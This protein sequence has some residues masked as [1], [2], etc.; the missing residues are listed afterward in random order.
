MVVKDASIVDCE[1]AGYVSLTYEQCQDIP[2]GTVLGD[3]TT[4]HV[5]DGKNTNTKPS[6]CTIDVYY[7]FGQKRRQVFNVKQ[8]VHCGKGLGC[9]CFT[10]TKPY[11]FEATSS[12][13]WVA[14]ADGEGG[15]QHVASPLETST[16]GP[17]NGA[18][19]SKRF[20]RVASPDAEPNA[21]FRLRF[22]G[23]FCTGVGLQVGTVSFAYHMYGA[24][25]GSLRLFDSS[26]YELW[27]QTGEQHGSQTAPWSRAE[28]VEVHDTSFVFVAA[29]AP[30]SLTVNP[31]TGGL[32]HDNSTSDARVALDDV[33]VECEHPSPTVP[34]AV[35][36]PSPPPPL[37]E[38]A[39]PPPPL[40]VPMTPLS[41]RG[42][43]FSLEAGLGGAW[44]AEGWSVH[45]GA[46]RAARGQVEKSGPSSALDGMAYA[47]ME[48]NGKAKGQ[49][50]TLSY[51][52]ADCL[53]GQVSTMRF[54]YHMYSSQKSGQ[55]QLRVVDGS[56][57]LLWSRSGSTTT[58][59]WYNSDDV[60]VDHASFRFEAVRGPRLASDVAVD[61]VIV[62]RGP[63]SSTASP[64]R[65]PP[66][67]PDLP[68]PSPLPF[69]SPSP[70]AGSCAASCPGNSSYTGA[71]LPWSDACRLAAC[72][73]CAECLPSP[74]PPPMPKPPPFP[75]RGPAPPQP[76]PQPL[77]PLF[78]DSGSLYPSHRI[79]WFRAATAV[80]DGQ[81]VTWRDVDNDAE[82][83]CTG[84]GFSITRLAGYGAAQPVVALA[85][86]TKSSIDFGSI[87]KGAFD[88]ALDDTGF[89]ICSVTRYTGSVRGRILSMPKQGERG[90]Y[91]GHELGMAGVADYG[92]GSKTPVQT[93]YPY[94]L[95]SPDYSRCPYRDE[96]SIVYP[97]T[98]KDSRVT[99]P[100]SGKGN[101][102]EDF[103]ARVNA[104]QLPIAP[105]D[106][107]IVCGTD[108]PASPFL[109]NGEDVSREADEVA[110]SASPWQG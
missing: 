19:G 67:P 48:A 31:L 100:P 70:P 90:F 1:Q 104:T 92:R 75:P 3:Y 30:A 66:S 69:A 40:S 34:P 56:G 28:N 35:L 54:A 71:P 2:T 105:T 58:D 14:E 17:S 33:S 7:S 106:W 89:S 77:S 8:G 43:T 60:S 36:A 50:S 16:S 37:A 4:N 9:V 45:T 63:V 82:A 55:G 107:V 46:T 38:A 74:P 39:S 98:I 94:C 88:D 102:G 80:V 24:H 64:S 10:S 13:D 93:W 44:A 22:N 99:V 65:P 95:N 49:V 12:Q 23:S 20:Y 101:G 11:N 21:R 57:R 51:V 18:D 78:P 96:A 61:K 109:V 27:Q 83:T 26:G 52:A 6:G 32:L 72:S 53:P 5:F 41:E 42:A 68:P 87:V 15:W 91:H 81:D 79:R 110:D 84:G 62:T 97:L 73:A 25:T 103:R 108:D 29:P 76:P 47:L 86:S 85:G 59:A